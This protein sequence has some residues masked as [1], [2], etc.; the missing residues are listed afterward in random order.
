[1]VGSRRSPKSRPGGSVSA[2]AAR[3]ESGSDTPPFVDAST[4]VLSG[5]SEY[6]L[7]ASGQI[8]LDRFLDMS[9][10]RALAHLSGS[11]SGG[12]LELMREVLRSQMEQDPHLSRLVE[13]A[14]AS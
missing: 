9:V 1:M 8:D 7:L 5:Q 4:T 14:I 2:P 3:S 12:R 10:D 6:A 11:V 13:E